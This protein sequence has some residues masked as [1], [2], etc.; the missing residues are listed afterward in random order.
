MKKE[1]RKSFKEQKRRFAAIK[2]LMTTFAMTTVAVVAAVIYIPVSP[3]ANITRAI[4]LSTEIA[5]QVT[6]TDQDNALDTSTLFVVLENQLEYYEQ[7][8]SLGENSGYFDALNT[9]TE[10]H[11]SVYGSK[12]F[13]Q[14]RLDT[15]KL[16]THAKEGGTILSVTPTTVGYST[17]YTLDIVINDPDQ[18]YSQIELVYGI[19]SEL[20]M[21][22]T[23]TRVPVDQ[24]RLEIVINDIFTTLPIHFYLEG[25]KDDGVELLDTIWV[26][27]PFTFDAS[28][29]LDHISRNQVGFYLYSDMD[30][31]QSDYIMNVYQK[32]FLIKT[33]PITIHEGDHHGSR[34][35]IDDLTPDTT[36]RFECIVTYT[37]PH[38][39]A[40]EYVTL[41]DDTLTTLNDYNYTY[42]KNETD[43]TIEVS[44]ML[45]DPDNYFDYLLVESYDISDSYDMY[46]SSETYDFT[47][48]ADQ[49]TVTFTITKP[50]VSAYKI[51]ISIHSHTDTT[52]THPIDTIETP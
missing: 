3:E 4:P 18:H 5:Y 14:E 6:V 31:G 29:Y 10:Y 28:V 48:E 7:S 36:Y 9:S 26:T 32:E 13:G 11:L 24:P 43:D 16:T 2:D 38:T 20:G 23:Y 45:D 33:E 51:L 46:L 40:K 49:K 47:L 22:F 42:T 39:L 27:P 37:N 1:R 52:I 30:V 25:T 19:Q 50:L 41:F 12:G 15:I 17:D 34:F 44:L 35:T 8:L 21:D